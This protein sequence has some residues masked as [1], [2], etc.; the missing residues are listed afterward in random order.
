MKFRNRGCAQ[1]VLRCAAYSVLRAANI[2][3][4]VDSGEYG[5]RV[6]AALYWAEANQAVDEWKQSVNSLLLNGQDLNRVG[7]SH[8]WGELRQESRLFTYLEA[9]ASSVLMS[10]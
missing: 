2:Q 5:M 3:T 1:S 10:P 7:L 4:H 9:S 8:V 6:A